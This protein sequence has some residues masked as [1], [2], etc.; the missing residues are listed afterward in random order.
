MS[1]RHEVDRLSAIVLDSLDEVA[2][3]DEMARR[4]YRSRTQFFRIFRAV[5]DETP[6][7]M[8]RRLLL[9]R[10]AWQLGQTDRSVTRIAL[11]TGYGSLEAF[12]R[13]FRKAFR[14]SPSLYRRMGA[15]HF[16]LPATTAVHFCAPVSRS[17]GDDMDLYDIFAGA[18][19]FHTRRLL[20]HAR[21]LTPE[22]LDAP[23]HNPARVFPWDSPA[24]SLRDLLRRLVQTKEIWTAAL[25]GGTLPNLDAEAPAQ[26]TPEALLARLERVDADFS[27]ILGDVQKRNAWSDTFVDALCEPPETFS[28]VGMFAHVITFNTYQRLL[29]LDALRHMGVK[30]EGFGCPTEYEASVAPA[31]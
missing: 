6:A 15:T 5:I 29:A 20:E 14:I 26:G 24:Q 12:T 22:Q 10:A 16:H 11:D 17:G 21:A 9:E 13:A 2:G 25:T 18:E 19:S 23:L 1:A 28:F 8:R 7:A 4:A 3:G 30:V 27:R 31:R